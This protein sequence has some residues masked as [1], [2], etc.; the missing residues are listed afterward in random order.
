MSTTIGFFVPRLNKVEGGGP[1]NYPSSGFPSVRLSSLNNLM[2][3]ETLPKHNH[4]QRRP[5]PRATRTHIFLL[6]SQI[7]LFSKSLFQCWQQFCHW[8]HTGLDSQHTRMCCNNILKKFFSVFPLSLKKY[9]LIISGRKFF[10]RK[11][12]KDWVNFLLN[13]NGG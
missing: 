2:S 10:K 6:R 13:L 7:S 9:S 12:W 8:E 11:K 4:L 3:S 1:L 5:K